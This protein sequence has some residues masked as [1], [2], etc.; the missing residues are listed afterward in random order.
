MSIPEVPY[1]APAFE[2]D[3]SRQRADMAPIEVMRHFI[4]QTA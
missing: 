2:S 1:L 3:G 4:A